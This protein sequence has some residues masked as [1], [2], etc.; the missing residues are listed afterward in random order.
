MHK[1]RRHVR[2]QVRR[3][4]QVHQVH[5][6]LLFAQRKDTEVAVWVIVF[7]AAWCLGALASE[8]HG[9]T[10]PPAGSSPGWDLGG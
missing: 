5:D 1:V 8:V 10:C 6:I 4:V 2:R 3:Q 7:N 9:Y